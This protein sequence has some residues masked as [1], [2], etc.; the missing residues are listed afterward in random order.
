M[1]RNEDLIMK[2]GAV[3]FSGLLSHF[4]WLSIWRL[5]LWNFLFLNRLIMVSF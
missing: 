5:E 1:K 4:K 2:Y 3:N